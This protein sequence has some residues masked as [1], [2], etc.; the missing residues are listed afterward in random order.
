MENDFLM[1]DF[2]EAEKKLRRALSACESSGGC[3]REFYVQILMHMGIIQAHSGKHDVAR[4]SFA[5]ALE[6]DD[7]VRPER[8]YC[9]PELL[10]IFDEANAQNR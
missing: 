7:S 5:T 6:L 4:R 8:D 2:A 1:A 9:T 3:S 10:Y